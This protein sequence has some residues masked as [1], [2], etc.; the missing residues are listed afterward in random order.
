MIQKV[1]TQNIYN[2]GGFNSPENV[3]STEKKGTPKGFYLPIITQ[4]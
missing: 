1:N 4:P 3:P 2:F